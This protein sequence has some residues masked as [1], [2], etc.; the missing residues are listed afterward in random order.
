MSAAG[1]SGGGDLGALPSPPPRKTRGDGQRR[2]GASGPGE[3]QAL[4][5]LASPKLS[6]NVLVLGDVTAGDLG[7]VDGT[8]SDVVAVDGVGGDALTSAAAR[9]AA[10]LA[11]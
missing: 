7:G 5:E 8:S 6:G 4:G 11:K 9:D 3:V 1:W 2:V 10:M